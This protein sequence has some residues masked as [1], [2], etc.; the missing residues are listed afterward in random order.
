MAPFYLSR[1]DD[2]LSPGNTGLSRTITEVY[3]SNVWVTPSG[4][5]HRPQFDFVRA[6][7]GPDRMIWSADFPFL[8]LDGTREFLDELD[9]TP[10]DREKITH[11]NT[12]RLFR[13]NGVWS[14]P[15]AAPRVT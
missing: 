8:H 4:M 15:T 14:T 9:I 2:V 6:V 11:G 5:F 13:L 7:V 10:E 1:L 12:E 3:R